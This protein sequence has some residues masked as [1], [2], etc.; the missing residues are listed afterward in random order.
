MEKIRFCT[1]KLNLADRTFAAVWKK[2]IT[3]DHVGAGIPAVSQKLLSLGE[4]SQCQNDRAK[5]VKS[6]FGIP[7]GIA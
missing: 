6:R 3:G 5:R 1:L 4:A 7:L 2:H